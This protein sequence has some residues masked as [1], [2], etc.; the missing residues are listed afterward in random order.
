MLLLLLI[1]RHHNIAERIHLGSLIDGPLQRPSCGITT[2]SCK[3]A[4]VELIQ[5]SVHAGGSTAAPAGSSKGDSSSQRGSSSKRKSGKG[6][7][8]EAQLSAAKLKLE[9]HLSRLLEEEPA[10]PEPEQVFGLSPV[11]QGGATSCLTHRIA[12]SL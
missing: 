2:S 4:A 5:L 1:G 10:S 8:V 6:A 12:S 7:D 9:E 11:T 3:I